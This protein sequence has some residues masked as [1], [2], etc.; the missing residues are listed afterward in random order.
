MRRKRR[1]TIRKGQLAFSV[2]A[3]LWSGYSIYSV[4]SARRDVKIFSTIIGG[5][6]CA[7]A[8]Y[9]TAASFQRRGENDSREEDSE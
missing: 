8:L 5:F 9:G 4:Q 3:L 1:W 7:F 6:F 2:A